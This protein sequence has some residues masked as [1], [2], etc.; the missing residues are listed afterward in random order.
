[1]KYI[2]PINGP[3]IV[4]LTLAGVPSTEYPVT[5]RPFRESG[6]HSS[7]NSRLGPTC[8][9]PGLASTTQGGPSA[10]FF[11]QPRVCGTLDICLVD[12]MKKSIRTKIV[13]TRT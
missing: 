12:E 3:L 9:N 6:A 10:I 1:M 5:M 13:K 11:S 7:N 2:L 4:R 8:M